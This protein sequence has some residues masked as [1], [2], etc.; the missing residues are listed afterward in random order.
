MRG[1]LDIC[2]LLRVKSLD[3]NLD[4]TGKK[5]SYCIRH[6]D[7]LLDRY[8][9]HSEELSALLKSRDKAVPVRLGE[10]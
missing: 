9:H 3:T 2:L 8:T 5:I 7:A 6:D 4:V 10:L 1:C